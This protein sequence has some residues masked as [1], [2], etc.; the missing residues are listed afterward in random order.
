MQKQRLK[1]L[2]LDQ[3]KPIKQ[4]SAYRKFYDEQFILLQQQYPKRTTEELTKLISSKWKVKEKMNKQKY[5]QKNG[6]VNL[7][8]TERVPVPQPPPPIMII[9]QKQ[10]RQDLE[11]THPEYSGTQIDSTIK[12]E[13]GSNSALKEKAA[14]EYKK[15]RQEYENQ[16]KEFIIKYGFWPQHKKHLGEQ[17]KQ[18]HH[19]SLQ[20]NPLAQLLNKKVKKE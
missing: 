2:Q 18:I 9:F 13:W 3:P 4:S 17:V 16:K 7:S 1:Q 20:I 8:D 5:F 14:D 11:M 15:L 19:N 12:F 10:L 6:F